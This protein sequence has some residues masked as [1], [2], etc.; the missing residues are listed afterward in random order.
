[1]A[2]R[3]L[4]IRVEPSLARQIEVVARTEGVTTSE[5]L[6]TAAYHYLEFLRSDEKFQAR[7]RQYLEAEV[8]ALE[9]LG[10]EDGS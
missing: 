6:R 5:A 8:A 9:G 7:R 3:M 1:M 2:N 10:P 4:S